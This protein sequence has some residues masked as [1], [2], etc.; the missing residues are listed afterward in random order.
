LSLGQRQTIGWIALVALAVT[1][2]VGVSWSFVNR[3]LTG[4]VDVDEVS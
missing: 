4:Q 2:A 1:M 3:R